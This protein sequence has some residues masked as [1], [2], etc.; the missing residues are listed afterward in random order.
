MHITRWYIYQFHNKLLLFFNKN[1]EKVL[2][3]KKSRYITKEFSNHFLVTTRKSNLYLYL[4][5]IVGQLFV[6]V[7]VTNRRYR[8]SSW[9]RFLFDLKICKTMNCFKS[10]NRKR[11]KCYVSFALHTSSFYQL[12]ISCFLE[13][14]M[15]L[16]SC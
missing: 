7:Y 2:P 11:T 6:I 10:F 15:K 9:L 8:D 16:I 4:R 14:F 5:H 3:L 1:Q 13:I 12:L